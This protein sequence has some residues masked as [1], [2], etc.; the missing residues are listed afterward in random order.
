MRSVG[1]GVNTILE[2]DCMEISTQNY[3]VAI[4]CHL[5]EVGLAP[6]YGTSIFDRVFLEIAF[7]DRRFC[8]R[9]SERHS[10]MRL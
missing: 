3:V 1:Q 2:G 8:L 6:R 10:F 5:K 9:S 7:R 4:R